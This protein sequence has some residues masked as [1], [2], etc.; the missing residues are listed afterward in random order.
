M[1]VIK[2]SKKGWSVHIVCVCVWGG[3]QK[4]TY[5]VLVGEPE[6]TTWKTSGYM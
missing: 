6:E 3:E 2:E 5:E 1:R 4:C